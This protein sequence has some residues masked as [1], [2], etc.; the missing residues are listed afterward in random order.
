MICVL[1]S[2]DTKS[3]RRFG[4][5]WIFRGV[6]IIADPLVNTFLVTLGEVLEDSSWVNRGKNYAGNLQG[7]INGAMAR[8]KA[9][10]YFYRGDLPQD[11]L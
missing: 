5:K 11:F 4:W 8:I 7:T 2:V 1:A 10:S 9:G 6:V 3:R